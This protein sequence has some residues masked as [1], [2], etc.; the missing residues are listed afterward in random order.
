MEEFEQ[1]QNTETPEE[2]KQAA[3][4]LINIGQNRTALQKL[5][6]LSRITPEDSEVFY[7][8]GIILEKFRQVSS[9]ITTNHKYNEKF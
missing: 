1:E 3:I 5:L 7:N 2:I 9:N 8:I 4:G 6:T